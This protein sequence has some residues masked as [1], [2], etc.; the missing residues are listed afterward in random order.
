MSDIEQRNALAVM[1]TLRDQTQKL[2]NYHQRLLLLQTQVNMLSEEFRKMKQ[3]KV[4]ELIK[5]V[6]TGPTSS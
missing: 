5:A 3:E 2:E 1:Q 4:Q 6:G